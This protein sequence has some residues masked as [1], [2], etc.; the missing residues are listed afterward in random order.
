VNIDTKQA[1]LG[2]GGYPDEAATAQNFN[3]A[4]AT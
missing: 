1:G 3:H 2:V 4:A